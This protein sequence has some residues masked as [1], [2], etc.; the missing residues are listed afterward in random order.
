MSEAT[1]DPADPTARALQQLLTAL[2]RLALSGGLRLPAL[3]ELMKVAMVE[4]ARDGEPALSM[5]QL[6]VRTG[7]H[8]KDLRRLL[9]DPAPRPRATPAS[10]VFA[11]WRG[12]PRYLTARGR[13]R[14]L[15]RAGAAPGEPSFD[16]LVE[17]VTT[18][19][20][21]RAVLDELLRLGIVAQDAR[22]RLRLV[23]EAFVPS[24]D[25][26]QM[27]RLLADN[28]ADHL[29]AATANLAGAQPGFLEQA[30]FS[31]GLSEASARAFNAATRA[32]WDDAY[33]TLM[34]LLQQ[35]YEQDRGRGADTGHR[36]RFGMYGFLEKTRDEP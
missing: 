17:S 13:P 14:V 21:P 31:D 15:P 36:V 33:A 11:R 20:H 22:G 10:E 2:S 32:A 8:R 5:S 1:A 25:R 6:S 19:V 7:V 27:L 34:P 18:D 12:D 30:M 28:V 29:D 24:G 9:D 16:A 4:A 3:V 23:A 35:L 26:G